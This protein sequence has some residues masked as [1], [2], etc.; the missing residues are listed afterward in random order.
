MPFSERPISD[1]VLIV[2]DIPMNIKVLVALCRS[3][4]V[5][6]ADT[7]ASGDELRER[8]PFR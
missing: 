5:T 2:D 1:I 6:S 7:A 3:I 4:G 8:N